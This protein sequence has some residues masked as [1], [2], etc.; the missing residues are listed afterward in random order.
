M[1]LLQPCVCVNRKRG[2]VIAVCVRC[3][4]VQSVR[5]APESRVAGRRS[6]HTAAAEAV[7][8]AEETSIS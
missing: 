3:V 5:E 6:L 1:S 4:H 8:T 2:N 7:E